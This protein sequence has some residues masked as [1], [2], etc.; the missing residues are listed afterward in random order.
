[1]C[2]FPAKRLVTYSARGPGFEPGCAASKAAVL[3][4]DDPR[5]EYVKN[6]VACGTGAGCCLPR[7]SQGDF[8][9]V[10]PL[11]DPRMEYTTIDVLAMYGFSEFFSMAEMLYCFYASQRRTLKKNTR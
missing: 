9:G 5:A 3:P 11:D 1:M 2:S 7:K 4:L 8:Y 6:V 10:L